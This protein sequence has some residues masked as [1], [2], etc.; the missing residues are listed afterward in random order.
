MRSLGSVDMVW[1]L[2]YQLEKSDEGWWQFLRALSSRWWTTFEFRVVNEKLDTSCWLAYIGTCNRIMTLL[3]GWPVGE[4]EETYVDGIDTGDIQT[5]TA[6]QTMW[7][8]TVFR[9]MIL[10]F[11]PLWVER[12]KCDSSLQ[13]FD[14]WSSWCFELSR[15]SLSFSRGIFSE[16]DLRFASSLHA[17]CSRHVDLPK[18]LHLADSSPMHGRNVVL[19]AAMN[20]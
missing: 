14:F 8:I 20:I 10:T 9:S 3:T 7:A 12:Y 18:L 1:G 15:T 4:N 16:V 11:I 2:C 17:L 19:V 5:D 13:Q 6:T